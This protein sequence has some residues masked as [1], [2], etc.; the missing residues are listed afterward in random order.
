MLPWVNHAHSL[1]DD[2]EAFRIE[3]EVTNALHKVNITFLHTSNEET[4][5]SF[6]KMCSYFLGKLLFILQTLF[7]SAFSQKVNNHTY[8]MIPNMIHTSP[9]NGFTSWAYTPSTHSFF[10]AEKASSQRA[11]PPERKTLL[12]ATDCSQLQVLSISQNWDL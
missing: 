10:T 4:H 5:C 12:A 11:W 8:L 3:K 6:M 1:L 9:L 7:M 2:H